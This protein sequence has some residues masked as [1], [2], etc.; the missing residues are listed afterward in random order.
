MVQPIIHEGCHLVG[1]LYHASLSINHHVHRKLVLVDSSYV[2][3]VRATGQERLRFGLNRLSIKQKR[4]L[5]FI[6]LL[7]VSAIEK[8]ELETEQANCTVLLK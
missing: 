7:I 6:F 4:L 8:R 2:N 1:E 5:Q 3:I